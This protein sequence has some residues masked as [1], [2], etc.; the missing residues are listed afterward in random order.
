[1]Q[2]LANIRRVF[3]RASAPAQTRAPTV[4]CCRAEVCLAHRTQSKNTSD[5]LTG[6]TD[7]K[8]FFRR[9]KKN[10][11]LQSPPACSSNPRCPGPTRKEGAWWEIIHVERPAKAKPRGLG[12]ATKHCCGVQRSPNDP[13]PTGVGWFMDTQNHSFLGLSIE[14]PGP[15]VLVSPWIVWRIQ[16]WVFCCLSHSVNGVWLQVIEWTATTLRWVLEDVP[17]TYYAPLRSARN[18]G[19][20]IE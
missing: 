15:D 17:S 13:G 7:R 11:L 1:M 19:L 20:S 6:R 9:R 3:C 16:V 10:T 14:A 12:F 18:L 8:N 2:N 5:R 4:T